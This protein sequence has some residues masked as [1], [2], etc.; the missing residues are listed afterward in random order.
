VI[1]FVLDTLVVAAL[2]ASA[3][4]LW[5]RWRQRRLEAKKPVADLSTVNLIGATGV[6]HEQGQGAE[7]SQVRVQDH[8]GVVRVLPAL[9]EDADEPLALGAEILVIQNPT[10]YAPMVVVPN[11]LPRLEDLPK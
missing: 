6:L 4:W 5:Q 2:A 8:D 7:T 9:I 11:E 1:G 10:P 3:V